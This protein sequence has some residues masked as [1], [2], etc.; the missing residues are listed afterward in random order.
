MAG[1]LYRDKAFLDFP[2]LPDQH[3]DE[4]AIAYVFGCHKDER[5]RLFNEQLADG[6][7]G[8]GGRSSSYI[9]ALHKQEKLD[10]GQFAMCLAFDGGALRLGGPNVDFHTSE[11]KWT[12][13]QHSSSYN[14]HVTSMSLEGT[15]VLQK[16]LPAI[17]DSG[18]TFT[19]LPRVAFSSVQ[20][21][22]ERI[23][24]LPGRCINSSES[25]FSV[26]L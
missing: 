13:M 7:L 9:S 17:V 24:K 18:T 8:M 21:E 12:P 11:I 23:C 14:V 22:I 5:G 10:N 1:L 4:Y 2:N 3:Q 25:F 16:T 15:K 6:I 19:M 20:K 26:H